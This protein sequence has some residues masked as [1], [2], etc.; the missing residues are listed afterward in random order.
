MSFQ[1]RQPAAAVLPGLIP[2]ARSAA[3]TN[4]GADLA[5]VFEEAG[6]AGTSSEFMTDA[7]ARY[8]LSTLG[9]GQPLTSSTKPMMLHSTNLTAGASNSATNT[10]SGDNYLSNYPQFYP[11][12]SSTSHAQQQQQ[13]LAR[14]V[15]SNPAHNKNDF[16]SGIKSK[17][18]GS[19][20]GNNETDENWLMR[21]HEAH[22]QQGL[23]VPAYLEAEYSDLTTGTTAAASGSAAGGGDLP[24]SSSAADINSRLRSGRATRDAAGDVAA[25]GSAGTSYI[26]PPGTDD[27]A[28]PSSRG[29]RDYNGSGVRNGAAVNDAVYSPYD[30]HQPQHVSKLTATSL[31]YRPASGGNTL[32]EFNTNS[33]SNGSGRAPLSVNPY[34]QQLVTPNEASSERSAYSAETYDNNSDF[35][36]AARNSTSAATA[37]SSSLQPSSTTTPRR[38]PNSGDVVDA[39]LTSPIKSHHGASQQQAQQQHL[40]QYSMPPPSSGRRLPAVPAGV[41]SASATKAVG[42]GIQQHSLDEHKQHHSGRSHGNERDDLPH[43]PHS[44]ETASGHSH[45]HHHHHHNTEVVSHQLQSTPHR[46]Q[47]SVSSSIASHQRPVLGGAGAAAEAVDSKS[48]ANKMVN[49][50]VPSNTTAGVPGS[51]IASGASA[52][53][54]TSA[55]RP[56]VASFSGNNISRKLTLSWFLL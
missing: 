20:S 29:L 46:Q 13:H 22:L 24:S 45:H 1:Q 42:S 33:K 3:A 9:T 17:A 23:G 54:S 32:Q 51:R 44:T 53:A 5:P 40:P 19:S 21:Q 56:R 8:S 48:A 47:P 34:H 11:G 12:A 30:A 14:S 55:L 41:S 49:F 37:P 10:N 7:D 16:N 27:I 4:N 31:S 2:S 25:N 28:A 15:S 6:G 39:R 35:N 43:Q 18:D 26:N 38:T 36:H 50:S 52:S